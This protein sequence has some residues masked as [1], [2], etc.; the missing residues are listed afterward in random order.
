V[1]PRQDLW[2]IQLASAWN[3]YH[4]GSGSAQLSS[5]KL[6]E[7]PQRPLWS[8]WSTTIHHCSNMILLPSPVRAGGKEEPT[9]QKVGLQDGARPNWEGVCL[10]GVAM[11][12]GV[13]VDPDLE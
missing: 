4:F 10:N 1:P 9:D 8:L 5:V 6:L 3:A 2:A 13:G 7:H 12:I 11:W